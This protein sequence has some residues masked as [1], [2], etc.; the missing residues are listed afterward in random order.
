MFP[1]LQTRGNTP[2]LEYKTCPHGR[3]KVYLRELSQLPR[4]KIPL[5]IRSFRAVCTG[6]W[7]HRIVTAVR[8]PVSSGVFSVDKKKRLL[9]NIFRVLR[10]ICR[11]IT[12][13]RKG[14]SVAVTEKKCF[15]FGAGE[16][17][18][19]RER[20]DANA[21]IV[22][23]DGGLNAVRRCGLCADWIVGDFDSLGETPEGENVVRLPAAKD[24]TDLYE[25][26]RIGEKHGCGVF[27]LYGGTGGRIDHTLANLQMLGGM[28]ERGHR[29]Y[30]Y[31]NGFVFTA[32]APGG[33]FRVGGKKGAGISVFSLSDRCEG[34]TLRGLRYSLDGGVLTNVF[35]LG[36]SNAFTGETAEISVKSGILLIYYSFDERNGAE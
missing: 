14:R 28:A 18:G 12:A 21:L 23:A 10:A 7:L 30:L 1:N 8:R 36:V 34:V 13:R 27:H 33:A 20:P 9:Y 2:F 17:Y 22:A 26:V 25:A 31:G 4:Q 24:T 11:A 15:C 35:P 29:V 5:Q 19:L 32:Q 16:F 6:L 3:S